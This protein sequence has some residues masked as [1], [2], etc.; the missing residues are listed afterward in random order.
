MAQIFKADGH[1]VHVKPANGTDFS[2]EEIQ[3]IVGGYFEP[4]Y[5]RNGMMLAINEDGKHIEGLLH[6]DIA[7]ELAHEHNA[8]A[9]DD[10][11]V[12]DALYCRESQIK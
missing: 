4:I 1:I 5:L 8:K 2:L 7:T 10:F 6:N 12:G 9:E 3:Q 11:I